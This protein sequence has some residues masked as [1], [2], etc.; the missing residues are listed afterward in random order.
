MGFTNFPNGVASFGAPVI[1]GG[2]PITAGNVYFVDYGNG[3]D[4]NSGKSVSQAFKTIDKAYTACTTNNMDV[5][6]LIGNSTHVLTSAIAWTKNRITVIGGDLSPRAI[7]Q[8]AKVATAA[9]D[10]AAYVIKNTGTRNWFHN[11]KFI[12]NSTEATALT[13][14]QMGGEG[15]C[16]TNCSF[17]FG[18]ATN[19]DGSE[20]TTYEVVLGEDSGTFS[21]CMFGQATLLTTGARAVMAVDQVTASQEAKDNVFD[22]CVWVIAS[23]SSSAN[24][25]RILANTDSKF[26]N[27]VRNGVFFNALVGSQSA[28]A[29][30]DA[31]QSVSG[32]V[33]GNWLFVNPASNCTEFC[34]DDSSQIKVIGP[35]MDG[36]NPAQKIGIALTPA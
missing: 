21:N 30:D 2:L 31:V 33:E 29:L 34:T 13:V 6:V 17:T 28:A 9:T 14:A 24:F 25:I 35:A 18:T 8:N 23:S 20:T 36:T 26:M 32:L 12:Q 10:T 7:Q 16:Y 3:S 19:I 15:N 27:L 1:G 5:I 11:I 22:D 4:G